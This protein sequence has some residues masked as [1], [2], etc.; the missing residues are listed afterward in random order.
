M[1]TRNAIKQY[2]P[3][4]YYHIYT[5]GVNKRMVFKDNDDYAFFLSLLKRY[6][7][8]TPVRRPKHPPY[9][10]FAAEVDLLTFCLMPNHVH[11]FVYQHH[12]LMAIRELM[13]AVMTSYSKYFNQKYNRVG[14]LFQSRYLA[15]RITNDGYLLH[16]SRY[17]HLNPKNWREYPYSSIK[18]FQGRAFAEWFSPSHVLDLFDGS[19]SKYLDFVADHEDYKN[20][21]E[22]IDFD[23]A[24]M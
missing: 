10:T 5:R 6:L 4:S 17:I 1:P 23:L 22:A 15:S 3:Q 8:P 18:Y 12:N 2:A 19:P 20:T 7:S 16:I 24:H 21:I 14:P 9:R 11:L 13:S